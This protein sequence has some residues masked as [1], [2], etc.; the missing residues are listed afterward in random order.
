MQ[1]RRKKSIVSKFLTVAVFGL[2]IS[3][4][5]GQSFQ[6]VQAFNRNRLIDDHLFV[7]TDSMTQQEIQTW[8]NENAGFLRNW[9]D[10]VNITFPGK[11]DVNG[12][13]C[14]AHKATGKT[15]AQIIREASHD[16]QAQYVVWR[17]PNNEVIPG[18][19]WSSYNG[20]IQSCTNEVANW[21]DT[22]L[23]TVSPKVLL[24]TLQKEQSLISATGSY[25]SNP[26]AYEN[27]ACCSSNE[28]KL[29]W[30]MGYGVPDSGGKNHRFI[31]FYSQINWAAWQFRYNFERSAGTASNINWDGVG[32]IYYS[33]PMIE[34][35][36][37]RSAS[38]TPRYYNGFNTIDGQSI[39]FENRA[40]ASL[41]HYTPHTYPGFTGNFN[42]VQFY[43]NWFG[44]VIADDENVRVTRNLNITNY[45]PRIDDTITAT[46]E[47]V[48]DNDFP[49]TFSRLRVAGVGPNGEYA[50]F[51]GV[52]DLTLNPGQTYNYND[53]MKMQNP[54]KHR[55]WIASQVGNQ[56][57]SRWPT[58]DW[59]K[60]FRERTVNV[61][62]N[63]LVINNLVL[64]PSQPHV[65]QTLRA[66]FRIENTADTAVNIE[67][68]RVAGR[69]P[70]NEYASFPG[71]ANVSIPANSTYTYSQNIRPTVTG[72]HRFWITGRVSGKWTDSFPES[73][74]P[75][76]VRERTVNVKTSP[77]VTT[78][79]NLSDYTPNTG[80]NVTATFKVTNY[81]DQAVNVGL[82]KI[83]GRGP[84]NSL[85]SFG[86][87]PNVTIPA[88]STFTYSRTRSF[89][90]AGD[91]RF[92]ISN[93]RNDTWYTNYPVSSWPKLIRE[94][95][96]T[97][98]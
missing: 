6:P 90:Q 2:L 53:S 14:L 28:Y 36:Y 91:Y 81:S 19:Q 58:S 77:L 70:N 18:S 29:A 76:T 51:P 59:P 84:G 13:K 86:Q 1:L 54:G 72:N 45:T 21:P 56:W 37:I 93:K 7:D 30:S 55:F 89:S 71:V 10:D 15:A 80:Q 38:D 88:G 40:T 41:Y 27:P 50:S 5:V 68:M 9:R 43:T 12:N 73:A 78:N 46:F 31:G 67:F 39:Y 96:I 95:N 85:A 11:T 82:L 24:V 98:N 22:N 74:Y 57:S 4:F 48:N 75:L 97:V 87:I 33:G 16:W 92:W 94:R 49:V 17:K 25:S 79:F 52:T 62:E 60:L 47:V 65:G 3:A 20:T 26:S 35:T 34:G 8:L 66:T 69:G 63:P 42:F 44:P 64:N 61:R 23:R 32:S 83:S